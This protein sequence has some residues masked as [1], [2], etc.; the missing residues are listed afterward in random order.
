MRGGSMLISIFKR[1]YQ[2]G[3]LVLGIVGVYACQNNQKE[4][5]LTSNGNTA[6][7]MDTLAYRMDSLRILSPYIAS[8]EDQMDT[9]YAEVIYPKFEDSSLNQLVDQTILLEGEPDIKTY[10][11]NFIEGYGNFVEE[12][13]LNYPIAWTKSTKVGLIL[14]TPRLICI[15]NGTY[16][17]SGGAHGN[18][19]ENLSVFDI[20]NNR[21]LEL[22]AFISDNK[23]KEFTKIAENIFRTKEGLSDTS[24]LANGYFFENGNFSLAANYG[25]TKDGFLFHYNPYEIKPYAEGTTSI[26]I[27]YA[28]VEDLLTQKGK[29]YIDNLKAYFHSI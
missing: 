4:N 28:Q 3:F 25:I 15:K 20:E 18:F 2:S 6:V 16:E 13:N 7:A 14:N 12:N 17:Y 29:L 1:V 26:I 24:S 19:F 8:H 5:P 22:N 27:P 11:N 23:M 21:K 10:V 9:S